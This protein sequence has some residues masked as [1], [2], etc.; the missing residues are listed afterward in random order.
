MSSEEPP[1]TN[2]SN[3]NTRTTTI[4]H[5]DGNWSNTIR[6]VFI[7]GT[8]IWRFSLNRTAPGRAFTIASTGEVLAKIVQNAINDP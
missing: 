3:I 8:G 7:Y 6:T 1:N 5:D 4:I 2:N